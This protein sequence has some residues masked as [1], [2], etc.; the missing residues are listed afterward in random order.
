MNLENE[1]DLFRERLDFF[2]DSF[3]FAR[4]QMSVFFKTL[5]ERLAAT[6]LENETEDEVEAMITGK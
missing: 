6:Q 3:I 4:D 5:S 1:S 2:A